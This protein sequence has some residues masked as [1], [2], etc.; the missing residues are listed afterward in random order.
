MRGCIVDVSLSGACV[1]TRHAVPKM[2]FV[3]LECHA[4]RSMAVARLDGYVVRTAPHR[5]GIEWAE[6]APTAIHPLLELGAPA[7]RGAGR[8]ATN[9]AHPPQWL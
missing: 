1:R 8:Q 7:S 6:F 5:L 2:A 3:Q 4:L 9:P